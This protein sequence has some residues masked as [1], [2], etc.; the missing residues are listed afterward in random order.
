MGFFDDNLNWIMPAATE[1]QTGP[2]DFG[3]NSGGWNM[4]MN[5]GNTNVQQGTGSNHVYASLSMGNSTIGNRSSGTPSNASQHSRP[6]TPYSTGVRPPVS[7]ASQT[8]TQPGPGTR[9][10][11]GRIYIQQTQP[12]DPKPVLRRTRTT[13]PREVHF[14]GETQATSLPT[15]PAPNRRRRESASVSSGGAIRTAAIGSR[16]HP[17]ATAASTG[18]ITP[19]RTMN[20]IGSSTKVPEASPNPHF[21]GT[22][23]VY[24]DPHLDNSDTET[25]RSYTFVGAAAMKEARSSQVSAGNRQRAQSQIQNSTTLPASGSTAQQSRGI[26]SQTDATTRRVARSRTA[27]SISGQPMSQSQSGEDG[28]DQHKFQKIMPRVY[29]LLDEMPKSP[30]APKIDC[31]NCG[32][33]IEMRMPTD[34]EGA[35]STQ[36]H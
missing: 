17:Y 14:M 16:H 26:F 22:Y 4:P 34:E 20:H 29:D 5:I 7:Q 13:G 24:R 18:R 33:T 27:V 9:P 28:N 15:S 31:P 25:N 32:H 35:A 19:S 8:Q 6:Q 12:S 3:N 36:L 10:S 23:T 11:I 1:S 21:P 2:Q 30:Q